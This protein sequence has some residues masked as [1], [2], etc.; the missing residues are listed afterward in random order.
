MGLIEFAALI[1]CSL[2]LDVDIEVAALRPRMKIG[3]IQ[4]AT[5]P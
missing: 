4:S 2:R 1:I 3:E 5:G